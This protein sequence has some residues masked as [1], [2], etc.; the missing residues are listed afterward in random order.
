[1][2]HECDREAE[3]EEGEEGREGGEGREREDTFDSSRAE[4]VV[5]S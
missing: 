5:T 1:M 2:D 3:R 4:M